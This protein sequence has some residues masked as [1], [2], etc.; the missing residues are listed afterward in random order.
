MNGQLNEHPLGELIR[1]I[2]TAGLSGA[3]R[4]THERIKLV[5][6]SDAG[7]IIYAASNLRIH[8]LSESLRRWGVMTEQQLAQV[9][10]RQTDMELGSA[11]VAAGAL[12]PQA[13]EELLA[14]QVADA[15]RPALLW[16]D[17]TW[18]FDPRVRLAS[19]L[20]ARVELNEILMESAR[21]LPAEFVVARFKDRRNEKLLPAT[22]A[23]TDLELLPM[24]A[25]VLSRVDT[26]LSV[27]E[28]VTIS[29]L[30]EADTL[31]AVYTLASGGCLRR[32]PEPQAFTEEALRKARTINEALAKSA[33]ATPDLTPEAEAQS[34]VVQK[35]VPVE[36]EVDER[37]ELE[38]LF[39]RLERATNYYHVLGISRSATPDLV[40]R[41]YHRLARRFHPDRFHHDADASLHARVE[42]AFARIA[43]A[44]ETL[45]D[46][47]ARAVYDMKIEKEGAMAAKGSSQPKQSPQPVKEG[48]PPTGGAQ[49]SQGQP[50]PTA[51]Q[52]AEESFR[53]A[54]IALQKGNHQL[55]ITL[56]GEAARL[57]PG[58]P[59]YRAHYGRAL[60]GNPQTHRQAETEIQAA[61]A[62][63]TGNAS[64]RVMLAE[65]YRDL[66]FQR[67]AQGELERALSIDPRNV[68]ARQMLDSLRATK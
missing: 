9:G 31:R 44:Y 21:R 3:L 18:S 39:A 56:F 19:G 13:L 4:L 34:A 25:F 27:Y 47:Q 55:A 57:V 10:E 46:R 54:T 53:Q 11:L 8:R 45:K 24:E 64:Y 35:P 49:A 58:Q 65:F 14:R 48:T 29:G 20:R 22:D 28:L 51:Q 5:V 30:P 17:G 2:S 40:K 59:R 63:D 67:R 6:Y 61:I 68:A 16:T 62:M 50:A 42:S 66:G 52:R 1:E 23:P 12:S 26:P 33:P 36:E 15:L 60:S 7:E 38:E 41:T 32:E 43:H 37:E